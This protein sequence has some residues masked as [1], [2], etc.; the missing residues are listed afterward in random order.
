VA[1]LPRIQFRRSL[2]PGASPDPASLLEGEL[3]L[4]LADKTILSKDVNGDIVSMGSDNALFV[5]SI[6]SKNQTDFIPDT[7]LVSVNDDIFARTLSAAPSFV[8]GRYGIASDVFEKSAQD[9]NGNPTN[10]N[11]AADVLTIY[12]GYE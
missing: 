5:I 9:F 11:V 3:V 10:N 12:I 7:A 4:N 6:A 8:N 2:T 1:N